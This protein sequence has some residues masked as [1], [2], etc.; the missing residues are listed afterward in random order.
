MGATRVA[1]VPLES[2]RRV[3]IANRGEIAVRIA[4]AAAELG[5]E[6]VAIYSTAD[7]QSLHTRVTDQAI[8]LGGE[9]IG[10][11]LDIEGVV[12]AAVDTGCDAIH[13][14]YGFLSESAPFARACAAAGITFVG[15]STAALEL[16]GDKA[17]AR[18]L[19]ADQGISIVPGSDDAVESVDAALAVASEI[20]YPVM[21]KA[22]AGGGGRGMRRVDDTAGLPEAFEKPRRRS[23]IARCWLRS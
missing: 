4:R 16:F 11:Y 7:A 23:A 22:A 12:A 19:A 18:S 1:A 3:L 10:A 13:P 8:E 15:P 5:S 6:T 21:L 17:A 2:F 20:G 9:P 14:G